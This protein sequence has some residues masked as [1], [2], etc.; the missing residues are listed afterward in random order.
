MFVHPEWRDTKLHEVAT[1]GRFVGFPDNGAGYLIYAGG[2][3]HHS[4]FAK[5]DESNVLVDSTATSD[6]SAGIVDGALIPVSTTAVPAS[7][8]A[9]VPTPAQPARAGDGDVIDA[10][11]VDDGGAPADTRIDVY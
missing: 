3:L 2:R 7:P 1:E 9:A 10:G 6:D 4:R 11:A 5:F 8:P